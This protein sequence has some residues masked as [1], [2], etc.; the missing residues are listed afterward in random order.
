M[1]HLQDAEEENSQHQ[2]CEETY[3]N[4]E[5]LSS[6]QMQ[7]CCLDVNDSEPKT[8]AA[9]KL[10]CSIEPVDVSTPD[11]INSG[12]SDELANEIQLASPLRPTDDLTPELPNADTPE[13][14]TQTTLSLSLRSH[15]AAKPSQTE[16][17]AEETE[18]DLITSQDVINHIAENG[19]SSKTST[20]SPV[21]ADTVQ[22]SDP[23]T[24]TIVATNPTEVQKII[25]EFCVDAP[26]PKVREILRLYS[27]DNSYG[28]QISI[29]NSSRC[30][31]S[32][33][34]KTLQFLGEP[35]VAW[36]DEKKKD[37]AHKLHYR[38]QNLMP[39]E[40]GVCNETYVVK[41]SD[42]R[43]L[44][45]S[46]CGH[47]VHH[48]C[49][50]SLLSKNNE[51]MS[52]VD[53]MKM[54][55]GFH[56]L[57]PSC[58]S[59]TIPDEKL[60][61]SVASKYLPTSSQLLQQQQTNQHQ[62]EDGPLSTSPSSPTQSHELSPMIPVEPSQ[63]QDQHQQQQPPSQQQQQQKKKKH[64]QINPNVTVREISSI[65]P[66][67]QKSPPQHQHLDE[68][69]LLEDTPVCKHYKNNTCRF[70]MKG[71]GCEFGHPKRCTKLM[72]YGTKTGKG[73]N[74]GKNCNDFHPKMC[75]MSI[76][77]GEC[78]DTGCKLCHVKGTKRKRPVPKEMLETN[79]TEEPSTKGDQMD[80]PI[81]G[82]P[83]EETMHDEKTDLKSLQQSFLERISLLKEEIQEAVDAKIS[84]LL[85]PVSFQS[86][87]KQEAPPQLRP[88]NHLLQQ[89]HLSQ[90]TALRQPQPP[91]FQLMSHPL[92]MQHIPT[93]ATYPH[94]TYYQTPVPQVPL[95]VY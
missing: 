58:E 75:S 45:C 87:P 35:N 41:K 71:R 76:S 62:P 5:E 22:L 95:N 38:I 32:D 33:L 90:S 48:K 7:M 86:P 47:E 42:P 17:Y 40:C 50:Q 9:E 64:V 68:E 69:K 36:K 21:S 72:N 43:L 18:I 26:C 61:S 27:P 4:P 70:G 28:K 80:D 91:H 51:G 25:A 37:C 83:K 34:L 89:N 29:F 19:I 52:V 79:A 2:V 93:Y 67:Q 39:E 15:K 59:D 11:F 8:S 44:S 31:K 30:K 53:A 66:T 46:I 20:S 16:K 60:S 54:V 84:A 88:V 6:H 1:E 49:Y 13:I 74:L 78:F 57:C 92:A 12:T 73:C 65:D 82:S 56:H 10:E 14:T 63:N 3:S 55:P 81:R 77:K 85:N 94:Q 23:T 24:P